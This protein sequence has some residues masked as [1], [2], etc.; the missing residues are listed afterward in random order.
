MKLPSE[1]GFI[2]TQSGSFQ[3]EAHAFYR[4]LLTDS[5]AQAS[6][7]IFGGTLLYAGELDASG[8]AAAIAGNVAGCAT[9]GV[10][11]NEAAQKQVIRDGVVDFMVTT[12]DEALRILKNEIRKR[13]SV[14]VC[15]GDAR[16]AVER[17]MI[18]RGV[19]P[20]LVFAG[21][22]DQRREVSCFGKHV[23]EVVVS[24]PEGNAGA[25]AWQVAQAWSR[26]MPKLD[27]IA[28]DCLTDD[29]W[30]RRWI[31]LGPRYFGRANAGERAF[32]CEPQAAREIVRRF[33][34]SV[35]S[36][37]IASEVS[38]SMTLD[39]ESKRLRLQPQTV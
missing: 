27:A 11:A 31:R 29:Q 30:T 16:E 19:L 38:V 28:G 5:A 35:E 9:L 25:L 7:S 33:A 36:G 1:A 4:A 14:G 12:L 24:R 18:E 21:T 20:D 26:W 34:D 15:L 37:A 22:I 8:R 10:I 32:Y 39:G 6:E 13:N 3:L 17:E 23:R 2:L